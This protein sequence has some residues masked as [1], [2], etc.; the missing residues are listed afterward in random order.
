MPTEDFTA[1][2]NS[3]VIYTT[4]GGETRKQIIFKYKNNLNC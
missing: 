4:V 1:Y 2:L 3:L